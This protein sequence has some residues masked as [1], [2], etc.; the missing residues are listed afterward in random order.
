MK[1][2]KFVGI[3]KYKIKVISIFVV[4]S[5]ATPF[6]VNEYKKIYQYCTDRMNL[7]VEGM[8]LD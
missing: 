4:L 6:Y 3:D 1:R 2:I 8:Y 7:S 5:I